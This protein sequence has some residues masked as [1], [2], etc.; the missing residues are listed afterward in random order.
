[1]V[2]HWILAA[3]ITALPEESPAPAFVRSYEA[4]IEFGETQD[5]GND[6]LHAVEASHCI[7]FVHGA[8][9]IAAVA[10]KINVGNSEICVPAGVIPERVIRRVV[11]NATDNPDMVTQAKDARSLVLVA[12]AQ[13]FPCS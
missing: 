2:T 4:A 13:L 8:V 1:M 12:M 9:E 11:A 10:R 3:L 6:V 5:G 7:G